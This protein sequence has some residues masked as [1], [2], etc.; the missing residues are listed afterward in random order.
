MT[1][2]ATDFFTLSHTAI[3]LV[4]IA[5]GFWFLGLML[6]GRD[7]PRLTATFLG[8]TALTTITGFVFFRPPGA[9]TPAQLTGVVA[10]IIVLPTLWAL[11]AARLAGR[12]RVIYAVG[13]VASLYLNVFV[14]VVQLFTKV[15]ALH[16]TM[17]PGPAPGG[18]IFGAAQGL[19][20]LGLP[21]GRLAQREAV[22]SPAG[23]T[24]SRPAKSAR[25]PPAR[26]GKFSLA[27]DLEYF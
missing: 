1:E 11:Y 5:L 19:V 26:R 22:P 16:A 27:H 9:P 2:L 10:L 8:L 20:L 6:Q 17:P 21:L 4:A 3:S 15:P 23:L 18:P 7:C 12:W 14:L 25:L 13:A 24:A